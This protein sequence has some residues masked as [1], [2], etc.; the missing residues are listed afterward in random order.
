MQN[1]YFYLVE[2]IDYLKRIDTF[3]KFYIVTLF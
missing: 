3:D 1:K 2:F